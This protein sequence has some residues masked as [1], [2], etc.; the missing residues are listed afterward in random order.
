[1]THA[2][3]APMPALPDD[4]GALQALLRAAWTERD[5]V[6]AERDT[7]TAERDALAEQ[8][9][10]LRH[11]LLRLKRLQFGARSERLPEEQ[12]QLGLESLETA[13]ATGEAEA[14]KR[15]PDLRARRTTKRRASRGALPAHLPRVEVIL[16][17]EDTA[18]PCCRGEMAVIGHDTSE[19]LDLASWC[20]SQS[21]SV[22]WK[23]MLWISPTLR[24]WILASVSG[25]SGNRYI[26]CVGSS[27]TAMLSL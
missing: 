15:D 9:D 10:R 2:A 4:V 7:I 3:P 25:V 21:G 19:R 6:V 18:C 5:G 24:R 12:L 13:I 22:S 26:P 16:A 8:N 27:A 17:P 11:L 23:L 1:M 14:E 20:L